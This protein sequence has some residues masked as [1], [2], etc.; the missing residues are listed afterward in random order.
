MVFA[1]CAQEHLLRGGF[2]IIQKLPH[3][4]FISALPG[5][6]WGGS[7]L[8]WSKTAARLREAGATVSAS[9]A[10]R[11]NEPSIVA[12][13]ES[14]GCA[15]FRRDA[16]I[17]LPPPASLPVRARRW[18]RRKLA[19]RRI[20]NTASEEQKTLREAKPDLVVVSQSGCIDGTSWMLE[21]R[22]QG[23]PYVTVAQAGHDQLFH[24]DELADTLE[25]ALCGAKKNFFVADSNR[26]K[27]EDY[28]ALKLPHAEIVRNPFQVP[29]NEPVPW[30]SDKQR[31][32]LAQVARIYPPAKGQDVLFHVLS[33]DKWKKR[34]V[35]VRLFGSGLNVKQVK[36]L[37][38]F[39]QLDNVEFAGFTSNIQEVWREH[40]ALLLPSRIEGL[41]IALV[42]AMLCGRPAIV[43]DIAGNPEVMEDGK[44]GFIAAAPTVSAFDQAMDRLWESR[45]ELAEMGN[46]AAQHIRSLVPGD[47]VGDFEQ[48]LLSLI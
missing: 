34:N 9:V 17:P 25:P 37:A 47:P 30:P 45:E 3:I 31:L 14:I 16:P 43:T 42:E 32:C 20:E 23:I 22:K 18:L 29:Y 6:D 13:L 7:E 10:Y 39:L 1:Q 27:V 12:E 24:G 36:K 40:H 41:P 4:L 46:Y 21:C 48:R 15:I 5:Y 35:V 44:T 8:L 19:T 2:Q 33:Q 26:K 38:R 11:K 28:L